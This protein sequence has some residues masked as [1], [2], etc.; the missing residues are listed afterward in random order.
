MASK[1][2][3]KAEIIWNL[4]HK[5]K[6]VAIKVY[7]QR[8]QVGLKEAKQAVEMLA[9]ESISM[10]AGAGQVDLEKLQ[11]LLLNKRKI[12][13]ISYYK[14]STG[15]GLKEAKQTVELLEKDLL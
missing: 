12:N 10:S 13:A 5:S 1:D 15:V 11:D 4:K 8:M 9:E 14:R 6:I 2:D 7:R 3:L